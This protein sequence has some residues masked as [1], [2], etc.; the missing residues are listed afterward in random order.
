M[1]APHPSHLLIFSSSLLLFFSSSHLSLWFAVFDP[2][3]QWAIQT[4]DFQ[5]LYFTAVAGGSGWGERGQEI[6]SRIDEIFFGASS[7]S[8][9]NDEDW[10][11]SRLIEEP[12]DL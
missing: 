2:Q 4:A 5:H 1:K 11:L 10:G 3:V 8:M 12:D 9:L 7:C 6:A